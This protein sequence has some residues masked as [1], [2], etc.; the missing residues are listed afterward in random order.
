MEILIF[1]GEGD[2]EFLSVIINAWRCISFSVSLFFQFLSVIVKRW[3]FVCRCFGLCGSLPVL[4]EY[5]FIHF[6]F[7]VYSFHVI[8]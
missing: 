2:F 5:F 3:V 7:L 6:N 1:K 8:F 4:G